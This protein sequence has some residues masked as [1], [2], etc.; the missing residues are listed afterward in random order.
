MTMATGSVGD[1]N[2]CTVT[3]QVVGGEMNGRMR[4]SLHTLR[5]PYASLS[6]T[7]QSIHRRGG[8][9]VQVTVSAP[10][11]PSNRLAPPSIESRRPQQTISPVVPQPAALTSSP[12]KPKAAGSYPTTK[13]QQSDSTRTSKATNNTSAPPK[14]Q[15]AK[16][17]RR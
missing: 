10:E 14:R 16:S 15:S 1:C 5:V 12:Q 17:K 6:K 2:S 11:R 4:T 3:L 9:I 7:I 8:K 13:G